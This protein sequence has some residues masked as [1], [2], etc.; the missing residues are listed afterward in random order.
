MKAFLIIALVLAFVIGG[1]MTLLRARSAP[2]SAEVQDRVKQRERDI[3]AAEKSER[4][5]DERG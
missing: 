3:E 5:R 2:P 4:D 1:L